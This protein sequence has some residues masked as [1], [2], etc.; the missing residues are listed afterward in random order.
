MNANGRR[1]T[2][3]LV[4]DDVELKRVLTGLLERRGWGC[5]LSSRAAE[6]K[7]MAEHLSPGVMVVAMRS[8]EETCGLCEALGPLRDRFRLPLFAMGNIP[9]KPALSRVVGLEIDAFLARRGLKKRGFLDRVERSL[10][11]G[12][13]SI[14]QTAMA[15]ETGDM[16]SETLASLAPILTLREVA[17]VVHD[18]LEALRRPTPDLDRVV[19]IVKR[20]PVLP[21][22]A[23][24]FARASRCPGKRSV[25]TV[26]QAVMSLGAGGVER[27]VVGCY[28]FWRLA[29]DARRLRLDAM[30]SQE[31][32]IACA[33][34][35]RRLSQTVG[36][37]PEEQAYVAGLLHDIGIVLL[38]GNLPTLYAR[39][40][41]K[42]R[43]EGVRILDA[44]REVFG[45]DHGEVGVALVRSWG[46]PDFI[47]DPLQDCHLPSATSE[48]GR[49]VRTAGIIASELGMGVLGEFKT[50]EGFPEEAG[51][52]LGLST[53]TI[54]DL[55]HGLVEQAL[56]VR[57]VFRLPPP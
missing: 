15:R 2:F 53:E 31:H 46:L 16:R 27:L 48:L 17:Q 3:L 35:S 41:Q 55:C 42:V 4:T 9:G 7:V 26:R 21:E 22:M 24:R 6:A 37:V 44:E 11:D 52:S 38:L 34:L 1:I 54:K 23:Q 5:V 57:N 18:V 56:R 47:L 40:L 39:V 49:I 51:S 10:A 30:K 14:A 28:V 8:L 32:S 13:R 20:D 12:R 33:I 19:S 36:N 43:G 45:I 50:H 29:K 25:K